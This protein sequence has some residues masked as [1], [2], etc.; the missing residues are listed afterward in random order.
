MR[1]VSRFAKCALALVCSGLFSAHSHAQ[2]VEMA[3][4]EL[5][6]VTGQAFINLTT[7]QNSGIDYTRLNLG[8]KVD[9]QLNIKKLHLGQYDRAGEAAGSADILID[10]FALGTVNADD[11]INPFQIANPYLELAYDG[12][13]V[14]GVRIGFDEA[15]GVLSGDIQSLTGNIPIKIEGTAAAIFESANVFEDILLGIAGVTRRTR[16]QADS[17]LVTA[18]GELDPVRATHAGLENGEKLTCSDCNLSG[19]TNALLSLFSSSDCTVLS[20]PTCFAL[21]DFKSLPIGNLAQVDN[22][23]TTAIEGAVRGFFVSLQTQD[24]AWRD[25]DSNSFRTALRG[26]FLNIPNYRDASGALVAPI[27][28]D[29]EQAF[30]GIARQ[31][32]CLGSATAGC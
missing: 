30:N 26:A 28:L 27:N 11:S 24:V 8:L 6:D 7:D 17:T 3:D 5:S 31:D 15:K 19:L 32:T 13:K 1:P 20:L 2:M 14:V 12:K 9:T 29:F 18:S 16:L 21:T 4:S 22:P 25:T 23:N 10:N